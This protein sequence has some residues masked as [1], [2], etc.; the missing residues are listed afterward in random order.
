MN[1]TYTLTED[2]LNVIMRF[3]FTYGF[4]IGQQGVP[5][6]FV[7]QSYKHP[8]YGDLTHL[9]W[10]EEVWDRNRKQVI[11]EALKYINKEV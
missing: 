5:Q 4:D 1:K 2:E 11:E 6:E 7:D 8:Y 3:S 9:T 10:P